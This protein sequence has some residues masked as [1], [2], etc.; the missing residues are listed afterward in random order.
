MNGVLGVLGVLGVRWPGGCLACWFAAW[1][2][3]EAVQFLWKTRQNGFCSFSHARRGDDCGAS[4][5]WSNGGVH[6]RWNWEILEMNGDAF[7][8]VIAVVWTKD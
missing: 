8:V 5:R 2:H 1:L 3:S 6:E 7:I 4:W